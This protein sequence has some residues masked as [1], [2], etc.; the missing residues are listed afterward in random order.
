MPPTT[1]Q[2]G[3]HC[4]KAPTPARAALANVWSSESESLLEAA[5]MGDQK[6]KI[7]RYKALQADYLGKGRYIIPITRYLRDLPSAPDGNPSLPWTVAP[8]AA[9]FF[10]MGL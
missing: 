1:G 6:Q 2:A 8:R 10:P 3:E 5:A 4:G 9:G 7:E